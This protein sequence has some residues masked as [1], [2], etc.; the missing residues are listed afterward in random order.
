VKFIC[1][2]S[3]SGFC[4]S[5]VEFFRNKVRKLI[6]LGAS[7]CGKSTIIQLIERFYDPNS[8]RLVIHQ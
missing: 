3:K 8:G 7:G 6:H 4:W 5:V 1:F 2:R